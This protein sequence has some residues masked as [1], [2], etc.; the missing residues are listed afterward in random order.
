MNML[1]IVEQLIEARARLATPG[2][3]WQCKPTDESFKPPSGRACAGT[4]IG[5]HGFAGLAHALLATTLG[6]DGG[7]SANNAVR[8]IVVWNDAPERTLKEV[9]AKFDEAILLGAT[10]R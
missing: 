6:E 3:W 4:A 10:T 7:I 5:P 8:A 2:V 9:L 1:A